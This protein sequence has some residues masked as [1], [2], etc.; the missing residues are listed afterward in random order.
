MPVRRVKHWCISKTGL[1]QLQSLKHNM[2]IRRLGILQNGLIGDRS[3]ADVDM[4]NLE[5]VKGKRR[6]AYRLQQGA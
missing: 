2:T 5:M 1:V 3:F 6:D 4:E